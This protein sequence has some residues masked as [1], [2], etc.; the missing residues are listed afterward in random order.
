MRRTIPLL[1][2]LFLLVCA[3]SAGLMHGIGHASARH[4]TAGAS[5]HVLAQGSATP[6][7]Q[8]PADN[9][10]EKCFQFAPFSGGA[11]PVPP[12]LLVA[13]TIDAPARMPL[14]ALVARDA[15]PSRSRGPPLYL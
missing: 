15:P 12:A 6:A 11:A 8:E 9:A 1:L 3:Q 14:A 13:E 4:D 10:C 2:T 5:A 7:R